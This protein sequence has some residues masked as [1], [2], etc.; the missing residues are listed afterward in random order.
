MKT[1]NRILASLVAVAACSANAAVI[2]L[3]FEGIGNLNPVG[4]Y[5]NG[6]GGVNYGISFSDNALAIVDSDAGGTGNFGGEPSPSTIL[7]FLSGTAATLNYAAGFDT[8]FSFY[9]SAISNPGFIR[10]YDG[11]NGAGNLL[12]TLNLPLTPFNGAP[13]PTGS[14]S[15]FVPVGVA[16]TGTARSVD[17]GGVV[18][19]IGFDNITFGSETPGGANVPDGGSSALL[20]SLGVLGLAGVRRRMSA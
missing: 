2:T 9:Y 18:D 20:L 16:F 5:Y 17:F 8:G 12:A 1:L 3:D 6:G 11:L 15:P 7:F 10:V 19:Q 13:D 4:N 14:Y